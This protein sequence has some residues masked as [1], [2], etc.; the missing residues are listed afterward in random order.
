MENA[1]QVHSLQHSHNKDGSVSADQL[2]PHVKKSHLSHVK[3]PAVLLTNLSYWDVVS[4][5]VAIKCIT[6]G[7]QLLL[8]NLAHT[9]HQSPVLS[10]KHH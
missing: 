4:L 7:F 5:D 6:E 1:K 8:N 10:K 2:V 3:D 9:C